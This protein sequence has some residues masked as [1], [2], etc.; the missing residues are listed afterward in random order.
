MDVQRQKRNRV[1]VFLFSLFLLVSMC[2]SGGHADRGKVERIAALVLAEFS[3][4]AGDA[5]LY[6]GN[7]PFIEQAAEVRSSFETE[8]VF[9]P[10]S[11][12]GEGTFRGRE[13]TLRAEDTAA[14]VSCAVF[15]VPLFLSVFSCITGRRKAEH[16]YFRLF[17]GRC[18]PSF[19]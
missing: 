2:I 13:N 18:P 11:R 4:T 10:V 6:S 3:G 1:S 16:R 15:P 17:S 14:C 12:P 9:R 5:E 7:S 19:L 8:P